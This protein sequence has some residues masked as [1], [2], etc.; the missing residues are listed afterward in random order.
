[1][2]LKELLSASGNGKDWV[3][4]MN[5]LLLPIAIQPKW[6]LAMGFPANWQTH[7]IWSK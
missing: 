6:Q 7:P 5:Q 1:L 3:A 2:I 4:K